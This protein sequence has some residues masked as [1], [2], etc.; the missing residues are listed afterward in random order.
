MAKSKFQCQNNLS[1]C[2]AAQKLQ[3]PQKSI[4]KDYNDQDL[5]RAG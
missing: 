3:R 1:F 2:C 4:F 5:V